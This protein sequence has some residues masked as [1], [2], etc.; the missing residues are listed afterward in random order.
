MVSPAT[1]TS[2]TFDKTFA[3]AGGR[4]IGA[5]SGLMSFSG[6][7]ID[8]HVAEI[9]TNYLSPA[10]ELETLSAKL[11]TEMRKRL[12]AIDSQEV[13]FPCRRLDILVVGGAKVTR[14]NMRIVSI[15]FY[16]TG[17]AI[18]SESD[19]VAADRQN[20]YYVR[21]EDMAAAAAHLASGGLETHIPHANQLW[22][23]VG[24]ALFARLRQEWECL[25]VF[26]Q[27]TAAILGAASRHKST[28]EGIT[29]QL[30]AIAQ[31]TRWP[32]VLEPSALRRVSY[33][34]LH[35][36]LDAYSAAWIASLVDTEREPLGE[37]P[38]DVIW[39]P[40]L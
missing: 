29:A 30:R 22:M 25:E 5:F 28:A 15:R 39:V 18:V 35:D 6:K 2:D 10:S 37:V 21:G 36:C 4:I 32:E 14:S 3:L 33:G 9:L 19:T 40:R 31:F 12:T 26:P 34:S 1:V 16:P 38:N 24:F 17:N 27:A 23:L 11:D 20:R 13:I 7:T 8:E